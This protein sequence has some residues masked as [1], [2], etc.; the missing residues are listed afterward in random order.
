MKTIEGNIA[1]PLESRWVKGRVKIENGRISSITEDLNI[2]SNQYIL[3]GLIDAHVHIESSMLIPSKFAENAVRHGTVATVSDP[4][5]IANVMGEEG[6]RFMIEDGKCVPFYFFFGA[7]SCVPAT[8]FETSGAIL[9]SMSIDKLMANPD[10][11]YLGEMMNFPGVIF[12]DQE[13]HSKIKAAQKNRKPVDGHAPLLSGSDLE[14]YATSGISTD[15][16]CTTINEAEAK[17]ALGMKILIREGSAACDFEALWPLIDRY[18]DHVMLCSDD[19][20]PDQFVHGH[21]NILVRRALEKGC[22]FFNILKAAVINPVRHYNLPVG[23]MRIGDSADLTIITDLEKMEVYE[24]YIKGEA[25]FQSGQNQFK[26]LFPEPINKYYH[27]SLDKS[28]LAIE[29]KGKKI[30]V[31]SVTDGELLTKK[32]IHPA[33]TENGLISTDVPNDILKI[34]VLNRYSKAQPAIAFI[35]GIGL[36]SG[37]I[38]SSVAHDSHNLVSVGTND[39]DIVAAIALI[40]KS[41]GGLSGVCGEENIFLPLPYAGLMSKYN[42]LE[43]AE[44][45]E[46]L[47]LFAKKH[48]SYLKSPYMTLAFMS[49]LVIPELKLGDKGLFDGIKFGFT[50]IFE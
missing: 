15:H 49:L 45:Y 32:E 13:I 37:A 12:D 38:A 29:A 21:I 10:I 3:P 46:A 20:H 11:W 28:H 30:K 40:Q 44:K 1:L 33:L 19:L 31:I 47:N 22:N 50:S 7:P 8:P 43:A 17:I 48:G 9:D 18:P 34:V 14:K 35:K 41:G 23:L 4:H 6:V 5:E 26:V 16:E 24:T 25:V 39:K 2:Q 42:C 36:K 27:N